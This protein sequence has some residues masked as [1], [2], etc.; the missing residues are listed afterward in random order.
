MFCVVK[1]TLN[2]DEP[3]KVA[4][5]CNIFIDGLKGTRIKL[6][7]DFASLSSFPPSP[8]AKKTIQLFPTTSCEGFHQ[9]WVAGL[10]FALHLV[11]LGA[12]TRL[13]WWLA[14]PKKSNSQRSTINQNRAILDSH[15]MMYSLYQVAPHN[16]LQ[17]Q[18]WSC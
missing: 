7:L 3:P 6:S 5:Q 17:T 11:H 1:P 9:A 10:A 8:F 16:Q 4:I 18:P 2:R 12:A 14:L 13:P 15:T